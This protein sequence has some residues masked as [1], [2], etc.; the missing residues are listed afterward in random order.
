MAAR[1]LAFA[2][3][4]DVPAYVAL[5]ATKNAL[6]RAGLAAPTQV[7]VGV[8]APWEEVVTGIATWSRAESRAARGLDPA[9]VPALSSP[10][11]R[12]I[13]DAEVVEDR[14]SGPPNAR[15]GDDRGDVPGTPGTGLQ[16]LEDAL[17]DLRKQQRRSW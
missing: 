3:R 10:G 11:D 1:L 13:V 14:P 12:D 6:D 8:T 16:T 4:E 17:A 9:T 2:E 15:T 5:D 7:N